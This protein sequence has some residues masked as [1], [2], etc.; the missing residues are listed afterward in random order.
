MTARYIRLRQF[1][2][3]SACF[4]VDDVPNNKEN[5]ML[6]RH[7]FAIAK[8]M[9][10]KSCLAVLLVLVASASNVRADELEKWLASEKTTAT[11]KLLANILDNGAVIASPSQN[12]PNYYYHWV[13]D[14]AL[15]MDVVLSMYL[16]ADA[17]QPQQWPR[18]TNYLTFSLGNQDT[19]N[20]STNLG[21]GLGEPKFNTDGSAF[22][23]PWGRPQDD[24]P[25][26]RALVFIKLAN[27]LLDGGQADQ[28]TLVKTKMY[29]STFPNSSLIKRDLEYVSHNWQNTCFDL[30]EEVSGN[31]FYTRMAQR[32]AL[33]E[34]AKIANR[35]NDPGAAN[36]YNLQAAA[37]ETAL[38]GHWDA[39][40]GYLVATLNRDGGLGYK[41][42][43]LDTAVVLA[44]LHSHIPGD[45]FFAPTDDMVLAT[46]QALTSTFANPNLYPINK[47]TQNP[48]GGV[49]GPGIGRYPEDQY[50]GGNPWVLCTTALAELY[51]RAA[52]EWT[53]KGEITIT[54][55]NQAF[56]A[57]INSQKFGNLTVGS[58]FSTTDATFSDIMSEVRLAGDGFMRRVRYHS[59]PDG[60]LSEQMNKSTGF[61]QS[62]NN[63]TWNY[64]S[65]LT[66]LR[67]RSGSVAVTG[68]AKVAPIAPAGKNGFSTFNRAGIPVKNPEPKAKAVEKKTGKNSEKGNRV[69]SVE[70]M[71]AWDRSSLAS[72]SGA[73]RQQLTFGADANWPAPPNVHGVHS[74]KKKGIWV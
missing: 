16:T 55:R 11:T 8:A 41:D 44:V 34:G 25:A 66:T 40:K 72:N 13:R 17:T 10:V 36:W 7:P 56:L 54:Q 58:T 22:Q 29:Q 23:G 4:I 2:Q 50:Y 12:D 27:K 59:N 45:T 39:T 20:P 53:K 14:G 19:P 49:M 65:I 48:E 35:L 28:V 21:R 67:H 9:F 57:S 3:E 5:S 73:Q 31:H 62:A 18:L 26:L 51:Y 64:A 63:L 61:M 1:S 68:A 70:A 60:S 38:N 74:R 24:G 15:T 43:N 52:N 71:G 46:A 6:A 69:S 37:I 32:R 30:W 47:V 42:S 33:R